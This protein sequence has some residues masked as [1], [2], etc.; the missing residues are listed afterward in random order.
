MGETTRGFK[1]YTQKE[2][3]EVALSY[4]DFRVNGYLNKNGSLKRGAIK[5]GA[6]Y[7]IIP[8]SRLSVFERSDNQVI[9]TL[10]QPGNIKLKQAR[11]D[12]TI[13]VELI[14]P[15]L[16]S[17]N[18]NFRPI[19][20][21]FIR[22][23]FIPIDNYHLNMLLNPTVKWDIDDVI[24]E[25]NNNG[26]IT[27]TFKDDYID[28]KESYS[29]AYTEYINNSVMKKIQE[30]RNEVKEKVKELKKELENLLQK[31]NNEQ[32]TK[33]KDE[34]QVLF[35]V[36]TQQYNEY[37]IENVTNYDENAEIEK[38]KKD[39]LLSEQEE[40][41]DVFIVA[42]QNITVNNVPGYSQALQCTL[43]FNIMT[44]L[45]YS[46]DFSFLRYNSDFIKQNMYYSSRKYLRFPKSWREL[47]DVHIYKEP[48]D[49]ITTT[50]L[51]KSEPFID[52]LKPLLTGNNV[53]K[54]YQR[55]YKNDSN[56]EDEDIIIKNLETDNENKQYSNL[57]NHTFI[58]NIIKNSDGNNITIDLYP[59]KEMRLQ[60]YD[61]F[62]IKDYGLGLTSNIIK[63]QKF[64]REY[65][66]L[67]E[68]VEV[69]LEKI[70]E[71]GEQ[72]R[73]L[74]EKYCPTGKKVKV[75]VI[76]TH[77]SGKPLVR[78]YDLTSKEC[79]N[80]TIIEQS[81]NNV[82]YD[83]DGKQF[84][85]ECPVIP[86]NKTNTEKL[87]DIDLH[88]T[89]T[90][91]WLRMATNDDFNS[92]DMKLNI[93]ELTAEHKDFIND[94]NKVTNNFL[95]YLLIEYLQQFNINN[96][97][98][99]SLQDLNILFEEDLAYIVKTIYLDVTKNLL[100]ETEISDVSFEN[101]PFT[102][103]KDYIIHDQ[104]GNTYKI[105][106]NA[107]ESGQWTYRKLLNKF[108]E[109][110]NFINL[111][112]NSKQYYKT[113]LELS[114]RAKYGYQTDYHLEIGTS[115]DTVITG[116][117]ASMSHK[118]APIWMQ[119]YDYPI[120]Q[121]MGRNDFAI[122]LNLQTCDAKF[123][124]ALRDLS[125]KYNKNRRRRG[126]SQDPYF[127]SE[128]N[129]IELDLDLNSNGFFKILG[130]GNV[131]PESIA[132]QTIPG[133]PG[134]IDVNMVLLQND[135]NI[136]KVEELVWTNKFNQQIIND[137]TNKLMQSY[138]CKANT[139]YKELSGSYPFL[140][141]NIF[142]VLRNFAFKHISSIMYKNLNEIPNLSDNELILSL[143]S[144]NKVNS[145][146]TD[147]Y[148]DANTNEYGNIDVNLYNF[149]IP[150]ASPNNPQALDD[151]YRITD[152]TKD[153]A[154]GEY[155]MTRTRITAVLSTAPKAH[156]GI[157]ITTKGKILKD[158]KGPKIKANIEGKV[159]LSQ[160][161]TDF[162]NCV[163]IE[164]N[165]NNFKFQFC[166]GHLAEPS[167]LKVGNNV[168]K[169]DFIGFMGRTGSAFV[170]NKYTTHLHY[171]VRFKEYSSSEKAAK[172]KRILTSENS[173]NPKEINIKN[174]KLS[175]KNIKDKEKLYDIKILLENTQNYIHHQDL[176]EKLKY[177][178]DDIDVENLYHNL[179]S[180]KFIFDIVK[181][182]IFYTFN[183]DFKEPNFIDLLKKANEYYCLA[184]N[185][186]YYQ[187]IDYNNL[188]EYYN[189]SKFNDENKQD[190]NDFL[191]QL[192]DNFF[193]NYIKYCCETSTLSA[194]YSI[195]KIIKNSF[196]V[197]SI[198]NIMSGKPAFN[199]T[200][201]IINGKSNE[202][203]NVI[204]KTE[205][206]IPVGE[207]SNVIQQK[208]TNAKHILTAL[209]GTLKQMLNLNV[210]NYYGNIKN[211]IIRSLILK[212]IQFSSAEFLNW[213]NNNLSADK[214]ITLI[215]LL[216]VKRNDDSSFISNYADMELPY[217]NGAYNSTTVDFYFKRFNDTVDFN[218]I[219]D[220]LNLYLDSAKNSWKF[221]NIKGI[222]LSE[223]IG[224][225]LPN[226]QEY[227]D[228]LKKSKNFDI[229]F[230]ENG[231]TNDETINVLLNVFVNL[232]NT[233]SLPDSNTSAKYINWL[234]KNSELNQSN[235]TQQNLNTYQFLNEFIDVVHLQESYNNLNLQSM[236]K[237]IKEKQ[238]ERLTHQ[239][240]EKVQSLKS[241]L[242][243]PLDKINN[244][245]TPY[246]MA[247]YYD[248]LNRLKMDYNN[249]KG[250]NRERC[251]ENCFPTAKIYF[252]E[253]DSKAWQ[254][255]DDYYAYDAIEDI[256]VVKSAK[257]A[258]DYCELT[259]SNLSETITNPLAIY[260]RE[261]VVEDNTEKEQ[262]IESIF[263]SEGTT[264]MV[265]LG[266]DN[267]PD[268]LDR[269]F[270][271]K[272]VSIEYGDR[273][274]IK[275]QGF[276]AE[277]HEPINNGLPDRM[278]VASSMK[279]HG[280]LVEFYISSLNS[281]DHFGARSILE[282]LG[283]ENNYTG[284]PS[285]DRFNSIL[286][287]TWNNTK[288]I[289]FKQ[290]LPILS[291]F[292]TIGIYDPRIENI[293]LSYSN[294]ESIG[295]RVIKPMED[296]YNKAKK[297][298]E[299][300]GLLKSIPKIILNSTLLNLSALNP[301]IGE[302]Y[303]WFNILSKMLWNYDFAWVI[304]ENYSFW[305]LLSEIKNYYPDYILTVLPYNDWVE[306]RQRDTI[307]LGP[308]K[309]YYKY[310]DV[311]DNSQSSLEF[312][313]HIQTIR[314]FER[315][316]YNKEERAKFEKECLQMQEEQ[317][318]INNMG[319]PNERIIKQK[320]FD[321]K[322]KEISYLL[323]IICKKSYELLDYEKLHKQYEIN[324][325]FTPTVEFYSSVLDRFN[326]DVIDAEYMI[327][328][329]ILDAATKN[330]ETT[331]IK[332][333]INNPD[334]LLDYDENGNL[335]EAFPQYQ[336]V[337][338]YYIVNSYSQIIS[339][340][341][342]A[343]S[344]DI[345]NKVIVTYPKDPTTNIDKHNESSSYIASDAINPSNIKT[346]I[347]H[348]NN[349][350]PTNIFIPFLTDF[351][352]KWN[353]DW[354]TVGELRYAYLP[355]ATYVG[356]NILADSMRPMYRGTIELLGMP[357][358]KPYDVLQINDIY[359]QMDGPIEVEQVI[360]HYSQNGFTTTIIPSAI[361]NTKDPSITQELYLKK[362]FNLPIFG[363]VNG[364]NLFSMLGNLSGILSG[365]GSIY[366]AL[367]K[368][369]AFAKNSKELVNKLDDQ[370]KDKLK[371][372]QSLRKQNIDNV[373]YVEKLEKEL[374][375][376]AKNL[377]L[378]VSDE[379]HN[380][381]LIDEIYSIK[382]EIEHI[383]KQIKELKSKK[384]IDD[385]TFKKQLEN[386]FN[387]SKIFNIKQLKSLE[388]IEK[389]LTELN[390]IKSKMK[391]ANIK[392]QT[393]KNKKIKDLSDIEEI[394]KLI[395]TQNE[396]MENLAEH[397]NVYVTNVLDES[398]QYDDVLRINFEKYINDIKKHKEK[399][400]QLEKE[401]N[402]IEKNVNTYTKN[403][404]IRQDK[405]NDILNEL[406][407][408]NNI[409][410][411]WVETIGAI[412]NTFGYINNVNVLNNINYTDNSNGVIN[413][414]NINNG[415]SVLNVLS[416]STAMM[417]NIASMSPAFGSLKLASTGLLSNP[418][419]IGIL[420]LIEVGFSWLNAVTF[421][422]G[423]GKVLGRNCIYVTPLNL[424]RTPMLAGL[425]G[426]NVY[427]D[428]ETH[429]NDQIFSFI[430]APKEYLAGVLSDDT[431][432]N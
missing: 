398:N 143:S 214:K 23:P 29:R 393:L 40:E 316:V 153:N 379:T 372:I 235:I 45:P 202:I 245:Y 147:K 181:S 340:N 270:M 8:P 65:K 268:L 62:E 130:I 279:L 409:Y 377:T 37:V 59:D 375:D 148:V 140:T 188:Q 183:R 385:P 394:K 401:V 155:G 85:I 102:L 162:G 36:K 17:I 92:I 334:D 100:N 293:Y 237:D 84:N 211:S 236:S 44:A 128:M 356:Y 70:F 357:E 164:K 242:A 98:I 256:K 11:L 48:R 32:D 414:E 295:N 200:K 263:L 410:M 350:D 194:K 228:K 174:N 271:G 123:L 264:I 359:N 57:P 158:Q 273:V 22:A 144:N 127:I 157:D 363:N 355:P 246:T 110:P 299:K 165:V 369:G 78:L 108:K 287:S 260:N 266:Y 310:T 429:I 119:L 397:L 106:K 124:S 175:V 93:I 391:Q 327:E 101:E 104:K 3:E 39:L 276:G 313:S 365:I 86:N 249:Y 326:V 171:E 179:Y 432:F 413:Y 328:G 66:H 207:S 383:S 366:Q 33:K 52:Y 315:K 12:T 282:R 94:V 5:I 312:T 281:L 419:T 88:F 186:L 311:F 288:S 361:I 61:A 111:I 330:D 64:Y 21:Q 95:E 254:K 297:D 274:Y 60:G 223:V 404:N 349:V 13:Q 125:I 425:K 135:I 105:T 411:A 41:S 190:I 6:F 204:F 291:L 75:E 387:Q 206:I 4:D 277:L 346:K 373:T 217:I 210:P 396:E 121:H 352:Q 424:N 118:M 321:K 80:Q 168:K 403:N 426:Y 113:F 83:K 28:G 139:K 333:R 230:N 146:R 255:L 26:I 30:R 257:S 261:N 31:L 67:S 302:N 427:T 317:E 307:Y 187:N 205:D 252:I 27:R 97:I 163:I 167:I 209:T 341:I 258:A 417:L 114:L 337:Q 15:D 138:V 117:T 220:R 422:W 392:I 90:Q 149:P 72:H 161:L 331:N 225:Q 196:D 58:A 431:S 342:T 9:S 253:E 219:E 133:K 222:Y 244:I 405:I 221:N 180:E 280:D 386:I 34:L 335:K 338:N 19:L 358:L 332:W 290:Y 345:Y 329:G 380:A 47:N 10:R 89:T 309:G 203:P 169:G 120:F 250:R 134:W 201:A 177:I 289:L 353:A 49:L 63:Q 156:H 376:I 166:Y 76:G 420:L 247:N 197:S 82:N 323:K 178:V 7:A 131:I 77:Y 292:D 42:M 35:D 262:Q 55:I 69:S 267:N 284:Y 116:M 294:S 325:V 176:S 189:N 213:Y 421:N 198:R 16:E 389:N 269:V 25:K 184:N 182:Y 103:S 314:D 215:D 364:A 145:D 272:I 71:I 354:S 233:N 320:E 53:T 390:N 193:T 50:D 1:P 43:T 395:K 234:K 56:S 232:S 306:G 378:Y 68:Y 362:G 79:I 238:V 2:I 318:M 339:N 265:K 406:Y 343:S 154:N 208:Y 150:F 259:I 51:S 298:I 423:L 388:N 129:S 170:S 240:V 368:T 20:A 351:L 132:M 191:Y 195:Y 216:A 283:I 112:P 122:E 296:I 137:A 415:L 38:A 300:K 367:A 412:Y 407:G 285:Q 428:I 24:T 54:H 218:I 107:S 160:Q 151:G 46:N 192:N 382:K 324:G 243:T 308:R 344:E 96:S 81:K 239:L 159:V 400:Q 173:I 381:D 87:S 226:Y 73:K 303:G 109:L 115:K 251:M 322:Y 336:Q 241:I 152:K 212:Y 278:G 286:T 224:E 399:L 227:I 74:L 360:H 126:E 384:V 430:N 305:D 275:A 371:R 408:V 304:P 142:P 18:N 370:V 248:I 141:K 319:D 172:D 348:Q 91:N 229:E 301:K 99:K 14:F 347:V 231:V 136:H 199:A 418:W 402:S 374:D 185:T 416:N